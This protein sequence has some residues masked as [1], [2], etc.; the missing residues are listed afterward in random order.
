M[1]QLF[2][3][4]DTGVYFIDS[5]KLSICHTKR[6]SNNRVF[7]NI[8]KIGMSSYGWFMGFKLHIELIIKVKLWQSTLPKQ[9]VVIYQ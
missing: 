5:T 4:E 7:S 6:T 3:G 9:I 2:R 8:T 1:L